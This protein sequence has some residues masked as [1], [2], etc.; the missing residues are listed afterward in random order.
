ME[1]RMNQE[2]RSQFNIQLK[3]SFNDTRYEIQAV[4]A[5]ITFTLTHLTNGRIASRLQKY[6]RSPIH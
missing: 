3:V 6:F 1:R 5:Y 2:R 4:K